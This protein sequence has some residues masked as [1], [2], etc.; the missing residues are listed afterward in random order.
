MYHVANRLP[1]IEP[2]E[3]RLLL[4]DN[5]TPFAIPDIQGAPD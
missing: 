3:P 2:L 1:L 4:S 5:G